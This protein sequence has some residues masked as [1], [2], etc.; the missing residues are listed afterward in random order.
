MENLDHLSDNARNLFL[1]LQE[2]Y[3]PLTPSTLAQI[4]L[5]AETFDLCLAAAAEVRETGLTVGQATGSKMTNPALVEYRNLG[6]LFVRFAA[7][8]MPLTLR[9]NPERLNA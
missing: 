1:D 4:R 8:F 2:G 9:F 5:A 3:D 6:I 7:P